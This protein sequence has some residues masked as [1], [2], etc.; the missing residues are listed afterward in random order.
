[1]TAGTP[2]GP[3]STAPPAAASG[4]ARAATGESFSLATAVGGPRGVAEAV[5]PG[6]AFVT[7]VTLTRDLRLALTIALGAAGLAVAVRLVAR[8]PLAPALSGAVGVGIC[9]WSAGRTGDAVDFYA[10]GFWINGVYALVLGLST[11]PWPR[12]GPLP[13]L[14]VALGPL[15]AGP[16]WRA[17]RRA[18]ALFQRLTWAF[19]ALFLLRLAV[20]LPLYY[21]GAVG[22]LGVARLVMGVPLFAALVWVTW[23][24]LRGLDRAVPD[25]AVPGAG[26]PVSGP[27]APGAAAAPPRTP[28]R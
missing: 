28:P 1:M 7:A 3:G 19:V 15:T 6:L 27:A 12:V 13:L 23:A 5:L 17:D 24:A 20:Q 16:A 9:A 2:D 26:G 8:Q 14:G 10:P 4:L 11:L 18:V 22:A 21:A 25:A